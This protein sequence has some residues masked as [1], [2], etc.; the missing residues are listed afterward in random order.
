MKRADKRKD[1]R[2]PALSGGERR[3]E[4][5]EERRGKMSSYFFLF[6][7]RSIF[8]LLFFYLSFE[9]CVS[10][11]LSNTHTHRPYFIGPLYPNVILDN[12][13][14]LPHSPSV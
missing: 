4:T 11:I 1:H 5:K 8:S 12:L 3:D 13:I 7:W 6:P 14:R 10:E 2:R 9:V